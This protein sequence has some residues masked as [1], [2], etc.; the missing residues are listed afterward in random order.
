MNTKT[1]G[2]KYTCTK[3]IFYLD[4][5]IFN[6]GDICYI[7]DEYNNAV[8]LSPKNR[9]CSNSGLWFNNTNND[10][11]CSFSFNLQDFF[12]SEKELRVQK[13][14]VLEKINI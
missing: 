12:I 8:Y 3:D 4:K 10:I 6:K 5:L 2:K 13:L 14:R 1:K 11:K 7:I 9:N